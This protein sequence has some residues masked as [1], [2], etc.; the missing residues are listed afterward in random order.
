[1]SAKAAAGEAACISACGT[2]VCV[3]AKRNIMR[4]TPAEADP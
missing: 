4:V 1:V 3:W 2:S